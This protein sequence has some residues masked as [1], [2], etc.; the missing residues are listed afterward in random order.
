MSI[1]VLKWILIKVIHFS[2]LFSELTTLD[3]SSYCKTGAN[4]KH[5]VQTFFF[6]LMVAELLPFFSNPINDR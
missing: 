5:T 6:L 4:S 3:A 1:L 2:P